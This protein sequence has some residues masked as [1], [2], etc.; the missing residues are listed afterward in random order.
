M[1]LD[2]AA[3]KPL[4]LAGLP[5]STSDLVVESLREA[6]LAGSLKPGEALVERRIAEQLGVSKTP[7]REALIDLTRRG[8][9]E[10]V[11]NR[12]AR[13][14]ELS[15]ADVLH[16][17]STRLLLEPQA[18]ADCVRH[19]APG[20]DQRV[21]AARM[22]LDLAQ[23]ATDRSDSVGRS[24]QN[25]TFHQLLFSGTPNY[26][27]VGILVDLQDV[28]ALGATRFLWEASPS[29][30]VESEQHRAIL[31]AV[32]A[33]DADAAEAAL[34]DHITQARDRIAVAGRD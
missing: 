30:R 29:W 17:Y 15:T 22:A 14:R 5:S 32:A 2:L 12:G 26:V 4:T 16:V 19:H 23:Q 31:D 1:S 7:V 25:R 34:T 10:F 18:V 28:A 6:I 21:S 13:V 8:L 3:S 33:R 20:F 9:V 24:E 27:V 11:R